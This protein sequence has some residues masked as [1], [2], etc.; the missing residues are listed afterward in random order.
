MKNAVCAWEVQTAGGNTLPYPAWIDEFE[1]EGRIAPQ[2]AEALRRTGGEVP[3]ME[4]WTAH[5]ANRPGAEEKSVILIPVFDIVD[6]EPVVSVQGLLRALED[7]VRFNQHNGAHIER[8]GVFY[9]PTEPNVRL[10]GGA[11][12]LRYADVPEEEREY[13]ERV[14]RAGSLQ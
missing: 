4:V 14:L 8:V 12:K 10:L 11:R 6:G 2:R 7:L 13:A 3:M 5:R 1:R 9:D